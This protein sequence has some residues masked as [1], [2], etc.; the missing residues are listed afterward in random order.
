MPSQRSP[1]GIYCTETRGSQYTHSG[2]DRE[3]TQKFWLLNWTPRLSKNWQEQ[4]ALSPKAL[5]SK[6]IPA[7]T[8]VRTPAF[9]IL[10]D[11][12]TTQSLEILYSSIG[13]RVLLAWDVCTG[14]AAANKEFSASTLIPLEQDQLVEPR[15]ESK[16]LLWQ[17][18]L[19][20]VICLFVCLLIFPL[21]FFSFCWTVFVFVP[22]RIMSLYHLVFEKTETSLNE[23]RNVSEKSIV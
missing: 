5:Q 8:L 11:E 4:I 20:P 17:S 19:V 21:C 18:L 15:W 10:K 12:V 22:N 7:H 3:F 1:R 9:K 13:K 2:R 16:Q 6:A 23:Y 14:R